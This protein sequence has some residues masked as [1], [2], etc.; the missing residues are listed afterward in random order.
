MS[1]TP[2][3]WR[4]STRIIL[5]WYVKEG[6]S[7]YISNTD[8]ER[9]AMLKAIGVD[10]VTTLFDVVPEDLRFPELRLPAAL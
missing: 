5:V 7:H 3:M 10:S 9:A 2:P 4:A 1:S 8:Q 6:M